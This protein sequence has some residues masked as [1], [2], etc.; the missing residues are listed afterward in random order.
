MKK[1]NDT[2]IFRQMNGLTNSHAYGGL[3]V[4]FGAFF[5][6]L[7]IAALCEGQYEGVIF[8]LISAVVILWS[9]SLMKSH[10]Y[11]VKFTEDETCLTFGPFVL[12]R[13][14]KTDV[15]TL[16][17]IIEDLTVHGRG[18]GVHK[19]LKEET[20]TYILVMS[21]HPPSYFRYIAKRW[22]S[23]EVEQREYA[24]EEAREY[25]VI[26]SAIDAYFA[27]NM[28]N[29]QMDRSDGIWLEYTPERYEELK[30]QLPHATDYV[31]DYEE[32][33]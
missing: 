24:T 17:L 21:P 25:A 7:G 32:N 3:F 29:F 6:F 16:C 15:Q 33:L 20:K 12:Q 23:P 10:Y 26:D 9:G 22:V 2:L 18:G 11:R 14:A 31:S 13:M 1:K 27:R 5:L 30:K 28:T 8:V 4:L 19:G